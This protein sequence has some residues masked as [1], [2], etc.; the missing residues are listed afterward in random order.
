M[1]EFDLI[2][3]Q[4]TKSMGFVPSSLKAMSKKPN[5][6]G[7][8][9]ML[10]A[11]INGF[12]SSEVSPLTA[13]KL[14]FKNLKWSIQAKKNS[15]QE[16]P[17]YLKNL[18]AH[19]V[20]NAAGCRYCQ[21]HTASTANRNGVEVKKLQ[22]IWEFQTSELFDDRERA[23]LNF[24]LAAGSVPNQVTAKHH[25]ALRKHFTESQMVEIVATI[26]VFGF[27]NRWNDSMATPLEEEPL[28]FA[29][30]H[31]STHWKPGKHLN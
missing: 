11:N 6:L 19:M 9:T 12:Q 13:L 17:I 24:A 16:V 28:E 5:I 15:D 25:V 22:S 18:V 2:F 23:A 26:S 14:M 1:K 29:S 4:A 8:F 27:L 10:F 3:S 7:S 31:L 21:A 20:S 30:K